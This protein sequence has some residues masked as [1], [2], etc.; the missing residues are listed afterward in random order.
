MCI[1]ACGTA[2]ESDIVAEINET[3]AAVTRH[4]TD[5]AGHPTSIGEGEVTKM[6][7]KTNRAS[8]QL[9]PL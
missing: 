8:S 7:G 4:V 3:I 6:I 5:L 1:A 2:A 9:T